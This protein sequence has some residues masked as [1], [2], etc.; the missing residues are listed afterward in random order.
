MKATYKPF[1]R[2]LEFT[3][4][5][6]SNKNN[7]KHIRE[8]ACVKSQLETMFRP[9]RDESKDLFVGRIDFPMIGV[10]T[11]HATSF[12]DEHGYCYDEPKVTKCLLKCREEKLLDN[13]TLNQVEAMA[14]YWETENTNYKTRQSFPKEL[15]EKIAGDSYK[16][17]SATVY[18]LYRIA[19]LQLDFKK[20]LKYGINGLIVLILNKSIKSKDDDM[21]VSMVSLL[22][23]I[24]HIIADYMD[25]IDTLMSGA[26]EIR[27]T[28]LVMMKESLERIKSGKPETLHDAIQ[29]VILYMLA[30]DCREIARLD[31]YLGDFYIRDLIDGKI[32][33]ENAVVMVMQFFEMVEH[34]LARDS[35]AIIGGVGR[36]NVKSADEFALIC[37]DALDRRPMAP[38]SEN[39]FHVLPQLSLRCYTGM[40]A[41]LYDRALS[42]IGTGR[43]FP[44]LYN[45]DANIAN[46]MRAFDVDKKT[47]QQYCF[48][49]C[50][51][52]VIN[53]K[54]VGTPNA[55]LNVAKTVELTL[56]N[57]VDPL[58]GKE[59]GVKTGELDKFDTFEKL[60]EAEKT[61]ISYACDLAGTVKEIVYNVC[62]D[63]CSF[64]LASV[65]MDD[66]INRGKALLEGG[67][68]HLGGTVE[69]YGNITSSDS[70]EAIRKVVYQDKKFTLNEVKT[71]I[72]NDFEGY[73]DIKKA[74][75]DAP[76]FG[77][78]DD[79]ADEIAQEIHNCVCKNLRRQKDRT[80]MD[81]LLAV[82]INNSLNAGMGTN[83]GATPDG[84]NKGVFLSNAVGAYNGQDK[85]GITALINS[86][87]K[88]DTSI[89]AGGNQ[90]FKF[91]PKQFEDNYKGIKGFM[92]TFFKLGG[93]QANISVLNQAD[94]EDAMVNPQNHENLLVR[95]GGYTARFIA[96]DK[97]TQKDIL[98]RTAY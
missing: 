11:L 34:E 92:D 9:M 57:G 22:N 50:G 63:E 10:F 55:L 94:L 20:L 44:L 3:K 73:E 83:T 71:A 70:M 33:R 42:I 56:N 80:R 93:Q 35:R 14:K 47:A 72:D 54:S 16:T 49:G 81:S 97:R 23:C 2:E 24:K 26:D 43:C 95:V 68:Q 27:K 29:L 45:D 52:Y 28:E 39:N 32:T 85:N 82:I 48:Y 8:A 38:G 90:N 18:P 79:E 77:N 65:L 87:T 61:Q 76:K 53:A 6:K 62:A 12:V 17:E 1:E 30:S 19:G 58:T 84:R 5:Y 36:E 74:L 89:H 25:Y 64:L 78:D 21:Y 37:L 60:M 15:A 75:L 31:D 59:I 69:S 66:C 41:R 96:L 67:V 91:S 40:D 7:S 4:I 13:E 46:V 88:L 98:T 86:M 51:E